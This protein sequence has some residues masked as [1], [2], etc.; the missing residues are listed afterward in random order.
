MVPMSRTTSS[1]VIPMPL[2]EMVRVRASGSDSSLI[3]RS[4]SGRSFGS[5]R[6]SIRSLSRASEL[7]ETNSRR[8]MSFC[9]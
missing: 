2:S 8:K 6:P 9:E 4:P 3:S 5:D 1:R 7:F